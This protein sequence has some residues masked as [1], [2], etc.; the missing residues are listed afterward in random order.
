MLRGIQRQGSPKIQCGG[1]DILAQS[2]HPSGNIEPS[3]ADEAITKQLNEALALVDVR[4]LDIVA[5]S[6]TTSFAA[7]GLI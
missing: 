3:R 4:S 1:G 7:R 5:G 2:N 6:D